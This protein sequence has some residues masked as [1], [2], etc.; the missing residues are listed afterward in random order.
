MVDQAQGRVYLVR[1]ENLKS[2]VAK[3]LQS[4]GSSPE[5]SL[6]VAEVLVEADLRGVESHGVTRL[7]GY[8]SMIENDLLN[9]S[10]NIKILKDSGATASIDGDMGF[11]IK[12]YVSPVGR[13]EACMV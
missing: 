10:P 2:Y 7:P 1:E 4:V 12:F 5:D 11:G 8:I 13:H 9:L 6:F 3:V